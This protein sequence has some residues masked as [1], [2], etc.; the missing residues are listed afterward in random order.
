MFLCL[1]IS[2]HWIMRGDR[3]RDL[4]TGTAGFTQACLCGCEGPDQDK[5]QRGEL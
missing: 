5:M 2:F 4:V 1:A 3:H